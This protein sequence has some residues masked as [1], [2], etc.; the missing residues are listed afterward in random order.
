MLISK[1]DVSPPE[2]RSFTLTVTVPDIN[3]SL[4]VVVSG[5]GVASSSAISS[6]VSYSDVYAS[7]SVSFVEP[8]KVSASKPSIFSL[9]EA[10][11]MPS[12]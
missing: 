8:S 12:L 1:E 7:L 5:C 11:P 2:L 10:K 9:R 4:L 3:A 6:V